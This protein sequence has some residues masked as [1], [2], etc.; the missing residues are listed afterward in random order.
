MAVPSAPP[1][2]AGASSPA[3]RS[4]DPFFTVII[5]AYNRRTFLPRAIDSVLAQTVPRSRYEIIVVKNFDDEPTD[6]RIREHALTGIFRDDVDLGIHLFSALEQTHGEVVALL[7]DDDLWEPGKLELVERRFRARPRLGFH[8][9]SYSV[10]DESDRLASDPRDRFT[11]LARFEARPAG[12]FELTP[13][14]MAAGLEAF[15]KANPGSDSTISIRT[16]I[17]RRF[18]PDLARLPSS[19]D[20]FMLTCG[21]LSG[22]DLVIEY[23][24][25]TRLRVHAGNMSRATDVSFQTY[26]AKYGRMMG[27][28]AAATSQMMGMATTVGNR[29][30]YDWLYRKNRGLSHFAAM[31]K[32]TEGRAATARSLVEDLRRGGLAQ[33]GMIASKSLYVLSPSFC[34][35][36]NFLVGRRIAGG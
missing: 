7:N 8:A 30:V 22:L 18:A 2:P 20:T 32:G 35:S 33:R 14:T 26:L 21:L 25:L 19:V 27:G 4:D 29:P 5:T 9:T 34:R 13:D 3:R 36:V 1:A 23:L 12:V 6:R 24:P 17:L 31:A 11:D 15:L 10:I 28:F 16:R